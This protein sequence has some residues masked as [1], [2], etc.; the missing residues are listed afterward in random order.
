MQETDC[1]YQYP[2]I[3]WV[4]KYSYYNAVSWV[5]IDIEDAL[6]AEHSVDPESGIQLCAKTVGT[7]KARNERSIAGFIVS[8]CVFSRPRLFSR[9]TTDCRVCIRLY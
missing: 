4:Y 7:V 3:A 2:A 6:K 8:L 1:G 9:R 5:S